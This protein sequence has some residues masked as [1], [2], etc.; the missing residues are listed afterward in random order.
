MFPRTRQKSGAWEYEKFAIL[1]SRVEGT[2][3]FAKVALVAFVV[4]FVVA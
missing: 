1:R 4:E 2:A 3:A